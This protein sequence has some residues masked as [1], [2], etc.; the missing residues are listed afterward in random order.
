[1]L[2]NLESVYNTF[3]F[4]EDLCLTRGQRPHPVDLTD[5]TDSFIQV[6]ATSISTGLLAADK[7][8]T[9]IV[10]S[11]IDPVTRQNVA[12]SLGV[13]VES[14]FSD[15]VT[16]EVEVIEVIEEVAEEA[17]PSIEADT[18]GAEK[19]PEE[20][21]EQVD[22]FGDILEGSAKAIAAKIKN[23]DLTEEQKAQLLE[24]EKNGKSRSAVLSIINEA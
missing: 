6:I 9:E 1:M 5:R 14:I 23:A 11:I 10:E 4:L 13:K 20:E 2:V 21:A 16:A 8:V 22:P 18:D 15:T 19:E 24:L 12:L 7:S 3:F 17:N